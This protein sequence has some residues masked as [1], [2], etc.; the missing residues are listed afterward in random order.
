MLRA[1]GE[2]GLQCNLMWDGFGRWVDGQW[3]PYM[4]ISIAGS[5][6]SCDS[7][8]LC[9]LS[10][11]RR[12]A[13]SVTSSWSSFK[14]SSAA[15]NAPKRVRILVRLCSLLF[16]QGTNRDAFSILNEWMNEWKNEWVNEC[17]NE[18]PVGRTT[19]LAISLNQKRSAMNGMTEK[20]P[21]S[22]ECERQRVQMQREQRRERLACE[23]KEKRPRRIQL[24]RKARKRCKRSRGTEE[25]KAGGTEVTQSLAAARCQQTSFVKGS[26]YA[27]QRAPA[28]YFSYSELICRVY[29][30]VND[31][32]VCYL[33]FWETKTPTPLFKQHTTK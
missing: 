27:S 14:L 8:L 28:W 25:R 19:L 6:G 10:E 29:S 3:R 12:K 18:V 7:C 16:S 17:M 2:C 24:R 32:S 20:T 4:N 21:E 13:Q 30:S 33:H 23:T 9:C 26:W 5:I 22:H 11:A 1:D 15:L 31:V